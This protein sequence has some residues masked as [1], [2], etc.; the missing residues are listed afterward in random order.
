M[1]LREAPNE[2]ISF[3]GARGCDWEL[4]K[5]IVTSDR[6]GGGDLWALQ[7]T[8]RGFGGRGDRIFPT[9]LKKD[10]KALVLP[11]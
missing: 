5:R 6:L 1:V 11:L 10:L 9:L 8:E 2:R 3:S 7:G 4:A